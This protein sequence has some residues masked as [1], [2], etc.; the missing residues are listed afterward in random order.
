MLFCV[1]G[2]KYSMY[3]GSFL[4]SSS[5]LNDNLYITSLMRCDI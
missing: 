2:G 3:E 1:K 4:Y 5:S